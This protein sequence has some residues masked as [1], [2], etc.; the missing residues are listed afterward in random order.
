MWC[1][2]VVT[3][4]ND[5]KSRYATTFATPFGAYPW[6]QIYNSEADLIDYVQG[7]S[8]PRNGEQLYAG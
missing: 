1:D 5:L 4:V 6:T 3:L 2:I 8:Y 7:D